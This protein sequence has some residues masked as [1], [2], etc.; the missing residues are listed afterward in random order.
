MGKNTNTKGYERAIQLLVVTTAVLT[1]FLAFNMMEDLE[2]FSVSKTMFITLWWSSI[3][4]WLCPPYVYLLINFI[5]FFIFAS[6]LFRS[7][8]IIY[9]STND[10]SQSLTDSFI[11]SSLVSQNLSVRTTLLDDHELMFH[12]LEDSYKKG[13]P[14]YC[15]PSPT[16]LTTIIEDVNHNDPKAKKMMSR[17][18]PHTSIV[19]TYKDKD[20]DDGLKFPILEDTFNDQDNYK[21]VS[22]EVVSKSLVD[23]RELR[24]SK[25]FHEG[26]SSSRGRRERYVRILSQEELDR[27]VEAFIYKFKK[28]T[29]VQK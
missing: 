22:K 29:N 10:D 8:S 7:K 2:L 24:K 4:P 28:D 27:Q 11:E 18:E 25:T 23:K 16:G 19:D 9:H 6:S 5:I 15:E 14:Y 3:N 13:E 12:T 1:P 20:S 26:G 21:S 17:L